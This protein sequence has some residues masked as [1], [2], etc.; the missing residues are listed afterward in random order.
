MKVVSNFIK[1]GKR[2]LSDRCNG[3]TPDYA[4]PPISQKHN[5]YY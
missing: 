4:I 3:L 2:L 1:D 5:H